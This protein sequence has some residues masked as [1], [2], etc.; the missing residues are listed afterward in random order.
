VSA[1]PFL[2]PQYSVC[3]VHWRCSTP[4]LTRVH[5]A[6]TSEPANPDLLV[7]M[8]FPLSSMCRSTTTGLNLDAP[9]MGGVVAPDDDVI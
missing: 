7:F 1:P 9:L 4:L 8:R 3:H 6:D 2:N 5:S